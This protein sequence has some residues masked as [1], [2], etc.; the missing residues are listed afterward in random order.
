[1]ST[2]ISKAFLASASALSAF[3]LLL[4]VPQSAIAQEMNEAVDSVEILEESTEM[5]DTERIGQPV[6]LEDREM[7]TDE[8]MMTEE[9]MSSEMEMDEMEMDVDSD[10]DYVDYDDDDFDTDAEVTPTYSNSPRA[11]W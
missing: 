5:G 10:V 7:V 9:S 6:E 4:A 11:L 3:G 2:L 1:M 8:E